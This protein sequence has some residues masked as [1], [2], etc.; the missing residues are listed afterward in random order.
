MNLHYSGM[1]SGLAAAFRAGAADANGQL[2]ERKI[3]DGDGVPCRHCLGMVKKDEPYLVLAYRPF[4][5]PQPYAEI[6]PVFIHAEACQTY[7]THENLPERERTG[8][9]RILRGYGTDNRIV[10][11]TGAVVGNGEIEEK[12]QAI[13]ANPSVSYVHM[14]SATNNCFTLRIDRSTSL[15]RRA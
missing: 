1:P 5:E 10:Y 14:R 8:T 11:G 7:S 3:S 6:G 15:H 13:L 4:P 2:P 9:G 12:V